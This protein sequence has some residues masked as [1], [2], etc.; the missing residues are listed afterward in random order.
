[1]EER[2]RFSLYDVEPRRYIE[3]LLIPTYFILGQADEFIPTEAFN[4]MFISH[5]MIKVFKVVAGGHAEERSEYL[6]SDAVRF[7]CDNF[8]KEEMVSG[9]RAM[10]EEILS[11]RSKK[12]L[13]RSRGAAWGKEQ[14]EDDSS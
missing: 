7:V 13:L 2:A 9:V 14:S 6:T 5:P 12:D 1:M 11:A 3:D 10:R 8:D 4:T